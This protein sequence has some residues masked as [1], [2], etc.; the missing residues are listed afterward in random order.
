MGRGLYQTQPVFR[1]A[2]ESC[3]A[4][5]RECWGGES[6]ID[7]LYPA[8]AATSSNDSAK[9]NQTQYTQPALFAIE[10][11]LAELWA[12]WGV[13][14]DIVLGHSVGEYV[15]ACIAGVM[16]LEDGL[17][18][19]AERAR[20]MQNVRRSGKMA[21]VF[22]SRERVAKE[23]ENIGGAVVIAVINGPENIVISGEATSVDAVSAKF[24][25][26]GIQVKPLNVSHAFHSPLM[27]EMLDEFEAFAGTIEYHKPQVP[28]AANLTGQLMTE[29]PTARYWRDHLRNAVQFAAGM[30][31][32]AESRPAIIIEM[33]PTASLL[34]MGRRCEPDLAAA[35]LPSLREGQDDWQVIAGSV[36]EYY[37]RGGR[38]DWRGWDQPWTRRRLLLPNYPFQKSRHWFSF[39]PALR[40]TWGGG[41]SFAAGTTSDAKQTHPLLGMSL[42]TVWTNKLFEARLSAQ[43]PAYLA[44]HQVQGSAVA[45]AAA[46]IEQG[47]AAANEVFGPGRHGLANLT[48]QQA[49]FLPEGV[50]RRVQVSIAPESGGEATFETYSRPEDDGGTAAWTMHAR[51]SLAHESNA[52]ENGE[53]E[54]IDLEAARGRAVTILSRDEFYDVMAE[55]GLAYGPAFRVLSDLHRGVEDAV[56]TVQL[57]ESVLRE[58]A[59]HRL[60]P[61][62]GDALLQVVA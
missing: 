29:A 52:Q 40:R 61:A 36:G 42:S 13:L 54:Q 48:I 55:R 9:V 12:S 33:G 46:Y 60:H 22:A 58:A 56:A 19:I 45:P 2:I 23:I 21:V 34:G 47:L 38:V 50:R 15:A 7:V 44:D 27:D 3:D 53:V 1:R 14:P 26:D 10:Y 18:L 28:L 37:V 20:L 4:V 35:W 43:S 16:S 24:A 25:A 31:R 39:D 17:R 32:V 30:S 5:L 11:A 62:L 49:M 6:L 41:S 59:A 8:A 57:P 51:G